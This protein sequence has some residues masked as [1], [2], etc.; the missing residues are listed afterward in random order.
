MRSKQIL[1]EAELRTFASEGFLFKEAWLPETQLED[2][3]TALPNIL[4]E[5]GP[6]RFLEADNCS[7]RAVYGLH[8]RG[9][10]WAEIASLPQIAVVAEE[11]LG[12]PVYPFQWKINPKVEWVGEDW[13]WH[14]DFTFW[15][16]EDGVT[17]PDLVTAAIFF[18][19]VRP[20]SGPIL[21]LPGSHND[22][23]ESAESEPES[24]DSS[25]D[26]L[27]STQ[28][29]YT[30][31]AGEV[32]ERGAVRP[33]AE[34][35]GQAGSVLFFH[36]NLVHGSAANTSSRRRAIGFLTF[37]LC[38]NAPLV[39]RRPAFFVNHQAA[40]SGPIRQVDS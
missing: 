10:I 32:A 6:Q 30:V 11:L 25:W 7:V 21:V 13:D 19:D 14:R 2:A 17:S 33:L 28:L 22:V 29:K 15:Q 12:G 26:N 8:Q 34:Q 37:N 38:S 36:A 23:A 40:S 35:V 20:E 24:S 9:G 16:H 31:L 18:D 4:H 3:V 5:E 1:S 39:A 27:V